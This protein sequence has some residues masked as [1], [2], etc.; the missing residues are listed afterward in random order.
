MKLK[1]RIINKL[2]EIDEFLSEKL[3]NVTFPG[4]KGKS[5]YGV[6]KFFF[7]GL[8]QEDLNLIASSLAFNFFIAVFPAIIFLFTLIAYIPIDDFHDEII[9]WIQKFLPPTA[10]EFMLTT[11]E[12]ILKN[13]NA[14]LLSFG[15]IAAIYFSSNGFAN[16]MSAFDANTERKYQ[17]NWLNI[18]MKS[19]GLTILVVS[20][21]ITT[22]V[23]SLT[24]SYGISFLEDFDW[25]KA[26]FLQVVLKVL[27][28]VLTITLVYLVFSAL[29]YFGSS[30]VSQWR[31]FS[32]G[33]TLATV[34]CLITTYGFTIYV[35]NFNSYNKLYGS[36]GTLLMLLFLFYFVSFVVLIGFELNRSID[37]VE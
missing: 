12:D 20:I 34:L 21:L 3:A 16:M 36:I 5:I 18:R 19:I 6:G 22:I 2:D 31:F 35:E 28:Y 23:L 30:K 25:I 24:F 11:I 9:L 37:K 10:F 29:Y 8:F 13:Q 14:G 4:L 17:R 33:S 27:E 26:S 32:A 15:F 1:Q 7:K